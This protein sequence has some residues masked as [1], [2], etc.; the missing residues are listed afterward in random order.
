MDKVQE[1]AFRDYNAPS[2]QPYRLHLATVFLSIYRQPKETELHQNKNTN[3]EKN[4]Q[5]L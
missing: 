3:L 5:M 4:L 1:T 2:S